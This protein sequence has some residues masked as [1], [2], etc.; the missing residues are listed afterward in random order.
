MVYPWL[1]MLPVFGYS[2]PVNKGDRPLQ[3]ARDDVPEGS[4][5]SLPLPA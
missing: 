4:H 3:S 1:P 2:L 5:R